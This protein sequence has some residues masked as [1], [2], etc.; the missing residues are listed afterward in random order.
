MEWAR[1]LD[2]FVCVSFGFWVGMWG[3]VGGFILEHLP[4]K[5]IIF[6]CLLEV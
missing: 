5:S 1:L 6:I 4:M 3:R 2:W